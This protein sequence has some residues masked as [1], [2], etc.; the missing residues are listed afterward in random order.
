MIMNKFV[1][2]VLGLLFLVGI[3]AAYQI[4]IYAPESVSVGKPLV[5][6]GTTTYG[7]GTPINVILYHQVT[8]NT[9]IQRRTG[10]VLTD[11]TFRV[12]FDTTDLKKGTY[13]VEVPREG[14]GDSIMTRLVQLI[15]RSDEIVLSSSQEQQFTGTL[16]IAGLAQ[17]NQ[18]SGIQVEVTDPGGERILGPKY[19][20]TNFRGYFMVD[21]PITKTGVYDVSFT[22][23]QGFIG[24][25]TVS[26]IGSVPA[27]T[28]T[29][30]GT[31]TTSGELLSAHAKSSRDNPAYFEVISGSYRMNIYTSSNIDWMMEY[32]DD[33]GALH[34][35]LSR[36]Q[37][38]PE[39]INV[40]GRGNIIYFKIYPFKY[41]ESGVVF[42]YAD[43]AQSVKVSPAVPSVFGTVPP[44]PAE[45]Q[46][47]PAMPVL[48]VAAV[49]LVMILMSGHWKI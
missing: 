21:V 10:Y 5:V 12:V 17:G 49:G 45:T 20:G 6:T 26:V 32:V 1:L 34:S 22:D 8:A 11:N 35:V 28:I 15:D 23:S 18:N 31:V 33:R 44:T 29:V 3:A 7:I 41:S 27:Q 47:S 46:K 36:N 19:I 24:T 14:L 25:K 4:T 39:E 2:P 48:G 16:T 13:K 43:N 38:N 30:A 42:L 37:F 40:K 9:E